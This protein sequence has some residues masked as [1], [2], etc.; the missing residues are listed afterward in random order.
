M[1]IQTA[2]QLI[3]ADPLAATLGPGAQVSLQQIA[4]LQRRGDYSAKQ[5][6]AAEAVAF[7]LTATEIKRV[8]AR[9]HALRGE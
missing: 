8:L 2:I 6:E 4:D 5:D 1:T 3:A 9:A 7:H